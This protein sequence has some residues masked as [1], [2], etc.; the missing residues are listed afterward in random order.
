MQKRCKYEKEDAICY[1]VLW[2]VSIGKR[3]KTKL[4]YDSDITTE[5]KKL[6][7]FS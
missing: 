2:R 5:N 3:R 7:L 4:D 6:T 1:R